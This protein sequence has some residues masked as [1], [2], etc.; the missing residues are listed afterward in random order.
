M[1]VSEIVNDLLKYNMITLD[2]ATVL[3]NA[4]LKAKLFDEKNKQTDNIFKP[5]S[6]V[7][8]D[9]DGTITSPDYYSTTTSITGSTIGELI[10]L[11]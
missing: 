7:L 9:N 2:A 1:T 5:Y 4:E 3:L 6:E 8:C 11:K 10:N